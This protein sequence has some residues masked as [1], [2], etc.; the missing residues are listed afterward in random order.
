MQDSGGSHP[1]VAAPE[2]SQDQQYREQRLDHLAAGLHEDSTESLRTQWAEELALVHAEHLDRDDVAS[3]RALRTWI[4]AELDRPRQATSSTLVQRQLLAGAR[5]CQEAVRALVAAGHDE[6][7]AAEISELLRRSLA[8]S[9]APEGSRVLAESLELAHDLA[10]RR[11]ETAV[12]RFHLERL[13]ALGRCPP[14][15]G[16]HEPL[17]RSLSTAAS[18]ERD[19]AAPERAR[20]HLD[21]LRGLARP[22]SASEAVRSALAEALLAAHRLA[23]PDEATALEVELQ[24]LA[25]RPGAHQEQR[26]AWAKALARAERAGRRILRRPLELLRERAYRSTDG[27]NIDAL[28]DRLE[29]ELPKHSRSFGEL[30][31]TLN[32]MR[33]LAERSDAD[34]GMRLRFARCWLERGFDARRYDYGAVRNDRCAYEWSAAAARGGEL[35]ALVLWGRCLAFGRGTDRDRVAAAEVLRDAAARGSDEAQL[36]L[37]TLWVERFAW[38]RHRYTA[39]KGA[40][41]VILLLHLVTQPLRFDPWGV[42][43]YLGLSVAML[44]A[45][46][47]VDAIASA[48]RTSADEATQADSHGASYLFDRHVDDFARRPWRI[49]V[50]ATE[51]GFSL[52]PLAWLGIGPVT[53]ALAGLVFGLA[54][55]PSFAARWCLVKAIDYA[56]VALLVLPWAGLWPVVVGHVLWDVA[57]LRSGQRER[58][59]HDRR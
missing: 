3:A 49:L 19:H 34:P 8:G 30:I 25:L 53:A 29:H 12:A 38:L 15:T 9:L 33:T 57:L 22:S 42:V 27:E 41:L 39:L 46:T 36:L 37:R 10:R 14:D 5:V 55:Y 17:A 43:A 13:R 21:D 59:A 16:T 26:N 50:V 1:R 4:C 6:A 54:H 58:T 11:G 52:A 18:D 2:R 35:E 47:L 48:L 23:T 45:V 24:S 40:G 31:A 32:E 44:G 56:L 51:D 7:A 20:R 28:F